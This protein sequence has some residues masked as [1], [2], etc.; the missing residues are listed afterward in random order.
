MGCIAASAQPICPL[1]EVRFYWKVSFFGARG[2][3]IVQNSEC[4]LF[5]SSKCIESTVIA[6]GALTCPLYG[7]SPLTEVPLYTIPHGHT[8]MRCDV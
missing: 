5:G 3:S 1:L 2:L 6:V 4:P 7:E 8:I